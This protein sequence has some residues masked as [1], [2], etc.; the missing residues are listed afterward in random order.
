M[1]RN[2]KRNLFSDVDAIFKKDKG[3]EVAVKLTR[4]PNA[5]LQLF[6][7][8]RRRFNIHHRINVSC[9]LASW[10]LPVIGMQGKICDR[11]CAPSQWQYGLVNNTFVFF[12]SK[13][14]KHKPLS[15]TLS[16]TI[17]LPDDIGYLHT[18]TY[19]QLEA[20]TARGSTLDGR[21]WRLQ[22]SDSDV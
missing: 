13:Q 7:R 5:C 16:I 11:T 20:L 15:I 8:L 10:I 9:L 14:I 1:R 17:D 3:D 21:I 22:T 4:L 2:V 19:I 12:T 18:A 6:H